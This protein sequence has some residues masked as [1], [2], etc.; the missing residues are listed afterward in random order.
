[1]K[2]IVTILI[3]LFSFQEVAMA[4]NNPLLLINKDLRDGLLMAITTP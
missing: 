4:V 2:N 1:M 3:F